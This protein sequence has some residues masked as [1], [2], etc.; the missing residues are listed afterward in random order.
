VLAGAPAAGSRARAL[1]GLRLCKP[2]G[3][4]FEAADADVLAALARAADQL[5]DAGACVSEASHDDLL[6]QPF[7]L[8]A[9][10]TLVA[11]EAAHIHAGWLDTPAADAVDPLVRSRI[12]RGRELDAATYVGILQARA[13]LMRAIDERIAGV[14]ALMLPTVPIVAPRLAEVAA[15]EDFLRINAL[16]L[17]NPS[18]FNFLDLPALSLPL[19]GRSGLPVGLML[20]GRRGGDRELLA[21]GAAVEKL[22][23]DGHQVDAP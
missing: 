16:V 15:P 22:L 9:R 12:L 17:R 8:Q 19:P 3:L 7:Q 4:P 10:G 18:I 20:I 21:V 6:A 23:G 1:A 14:D 11:A 13:A 2:T 5:V